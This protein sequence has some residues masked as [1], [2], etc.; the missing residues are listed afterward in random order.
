MIITD[1][2]V[3]YLDA[4]NEE[5]YAGKGDVWIDLSGSG[6]H[7]ELTYGINM[8]EK[9]LCFSKSKQFVKV[10]DSYTLN[11]NN[12]FTISTWFRTKNFA[13]VEILFSKG[14]SDNLEEYSL[15]FV[16]SKSVYWDYGF[17]QS[18]VYA[19]IP[20]ISDNEWHNIVAM[21]NHEDSPAGSI[22]FDGVKS[23]ILSYG[24]SDH[25]QATGSNL[26]IGNQ[27]A[28][29]IYHPDRFPFRG[30]INSFLAYNRALSE[31]EIVSNY[32]ATK[33]VFD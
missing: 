21:Y 3:L 30:L 20:D 1:G 22:Y 15:S 7:G 11:F 27:N 13:N 23:T 5:S 4:I 26:Y 28:G 33:P 29:V 18:Y 2:L 19:S 17:K 6:N 8:E 10:N 14:I 31:A 12:Q 25:I 9:G 24:N 32:E 16:G